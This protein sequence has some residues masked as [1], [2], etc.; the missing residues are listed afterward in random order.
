MSK[1]KKYETISEAQ[2]ATKTLGIKTTIEYRKTYRKDPRL[3]YEP[4][5]FYQE[6]WVNPATFF[7][8]GVTEKY[9][10]LAEAQKA[11]KTLGIKTSI[12]YRKT[13]RQDPRLRCNPQVSYQKEWVN[14]TTFLGRKVIELYP[15]LAEAQKATKALEIKTYIEYKN[16][17]RQD[18]RLPTTPK[19]FYQRE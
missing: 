11:T 1:Q 17:H 16:T 8:R 18:P 7:E 10:T 4:R 2:K 12:E 13:Y 6:E 5:K 15:T 14:W 3:P 9:A 19:Q